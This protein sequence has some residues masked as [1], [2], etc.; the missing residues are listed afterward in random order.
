MLPLQRTEAI[1]SVLREEGQLP[2]SRL[3]ERLNVSK[4]TTYRDLLRLRREGLVTISEGMAA[5]VKGAHSNPF[6]QDQSQWLALQ[7]MSALDSIASAALALIDEV[8][9]IFIGESLVCYLLA[10][11]IRA[12]PRFKNLTVVTNNFSVAI[13]LSSAIKHLYIIGGELLQN[14]ENLYTGGPKFASNLSTIFVNKAFSCVDGVD[15]QAG[16]T[17]QDLSQL[18]ILSHLPD[19]S[20]RSIFLVLSNKFGYRSVHQLASLDL[21]DTIIT[22]GS[23]SPKNQEVFSQL[24]KP[25]LIL[26]P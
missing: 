6:Q 14:A 17:M 16:Y 2:I 15:I 13:E 20:A 3:A 10:Q 18:N 25:R 8:D 5:L 21:G 1:K 7:D 4:S 26:A 24:E 23:L 9:S 22:D 12:Q 19:F 11:K